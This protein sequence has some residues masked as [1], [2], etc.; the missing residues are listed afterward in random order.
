MNALLRF[1]SLIALTVFLTV[2]CSEKDESGETPASATMTPLS[3]RL[4][5][6]ESDKVVFAQVSATDYA[7]WKQGFP[8]S[9]TVQGL[10]Q[11]LYSVME[12]DFDFIFL[13]VNEAEKDST[14]AYGINQTLRNDVSGI[15]SSTYDYTSSYG[16]S[17][18]LRSLLWLA[19][20]R[21]LKSGPSLH[22]ISH[23]WANHGINTFSLSPDASNNWVEEPYGAGNGSHW[24]FSSV[25]GQLGGFDE[26]VDLGNDQY[27][28]KF[29]GEAGFGPNANGGNG[30][31]YSNL[32]LYLMGLIPLS[33]V[34]NFTVF[35]G[36]GT[37]SSGYDAALAELRVGK[38]TAT[39][40]TEYTKDNLE[41]ALGGSRSPA[42]PNSQTEFRAI[43]VLI[44]SALPTDA[45]LQEVEDT[46]DWF[47]LS[48]DD[49]TAY[50]YNFY[51][52]TQ[53]NASIQMDQLSQHRK[54]SARLTPPRVS[55]G[56]SVPR[57]HVDHEPGWKSSLTR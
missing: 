53:G 49:G 47:S 50:Y 16:A 54:S 45:Q 43:A 27:Q 10:T 5:L 33:D 26:F 52:A 42:Y 2:A 15:G 24:G 36:L 46:L 56:G 32:E 48:G 23:N 55:A 18:T 12:D 22:E 4:Y 44:G 25:G 1:S 19:A 20:R 37:I 3:D 31:P 30:L 39:T 8:A 6:S 35:S 57:I 14:S 29:A 21:Y 9:A 28:G 7:E 17:G 51:E 13:I 41:A 11:E 40:L 34:D 38:F